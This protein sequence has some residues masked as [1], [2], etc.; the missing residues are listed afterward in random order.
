MHFTCIMT[1]SGYSRR[2]YQ[3]C[4]KIRVTY[5]DTFSVYFRCILPVFWLYMGIVVRRIKFV[6][7][8]GSFIL[9]YL[10]WI[11]SQLWYHS[12]RSGVRVRL[13][14]RRCVRRT[15]PKDELIVK[16]I[17]AF[18]YQCRVLWNIQQPSYSRIKW[19]NSTWESDG[20]DR[21]IK[22]YVTIYHTISSRGVGHA[23]YATSPMGQNSH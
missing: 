10:Q 14:R 17:I 8:Y 19:T 11:Y 18:H 12:T 2:T 1:V 13:R 15:T 3:I 9:T 4:L 20:K 23:V 6:W 16:Y 7:K 21:T 22:F 5:F